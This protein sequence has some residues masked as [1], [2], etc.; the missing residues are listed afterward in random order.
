MV[1]NAQKRHSISLSVIT[2]S[3]V[4]KESKTQKELFPDTVT[5]TQN[6]LPILQEETIQDIA[7]DAFSPITMYYCIDNKTEEKSDPLIA[8]DVDG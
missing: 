7:L 3:Q 6:D 1:I 8:F 4:S 5:I 2:I